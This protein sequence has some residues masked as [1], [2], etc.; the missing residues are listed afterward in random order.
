M[1]TLK[2]K[3]LTALGDNPFAKRFVIK[4]RGILSR[5]KEKSRIKLL[6]QNRFQENK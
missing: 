5:V 2:R 3:A 4:M 6:K 1:K